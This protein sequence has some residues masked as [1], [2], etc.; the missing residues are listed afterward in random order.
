MPPVSPGTRKTRFSATWITRAHARTTRRA[1]PRAAV[2]ALR[3][4][5]PVLRRLRGRG[6]PAREPRRGRA[7]ALLRLRGGARRRASWQSIRR[8]AGTGRSPRATSSTTAAASAGS[9]CR[10]RARAE[11]VV[12]VDV[13]PSML[14][15]A[16]RNCDARG[17][18]NV[19]LLAADRLGTL[20]PEFDLVHSFIVLQH[21]P[22]RHRRADLRDAGVAR[23]ARAA[24]ASCRCR[25]RRA[26]GCAQA[27]T[28]GDADA[29]VRLQRRQRP[30]RAAVVLPAHAD[31]RLP[32]QPPGPAA[33]SA[34]AT[35]W[36][37]SS[38]APGPSAARRYAD[39]TLIFRALAG[40]ARAPARRP[41]TCRAPPPPS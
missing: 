16:R 21:I 25:S 4:R 9:S 23:R 13:S 14:A 6:V 11:R 10:S 3:P 33:R 29:P 7:R 40:S 38:S 20:A 5:G 41:R 1:R 22:P 27:H 18:R 32:P 35:T 2:G 15:E 17:A 37:T 30:A 31:E 8:Y 28:L 19:E 39:A 12:G 24:S 36:C 26:T 34:R